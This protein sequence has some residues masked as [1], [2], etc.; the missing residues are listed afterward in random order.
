ME[1]IGNLKV[2]TKIS[3]YALSSRSW[4]LQ[5]SWK[6]GRIWTCLTQI[7]KKHILASWQMRVVIHQMTL[8]MKRQTFLTFTLLSKHIMNLS[9]ITINL[10]RCTKTLKRDSKERCKEVESKLYTTNNNSLS[11]EKGE[12]EQK[13]K[14]K[15]WLIRNLKK[16]YSWLKKV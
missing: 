6:H 5:I 7:Q 4:A 8:M 10:Y 12:L 11:N 14:N 3:L 2:R 13:K 1:K 15:L 9:L 16:N